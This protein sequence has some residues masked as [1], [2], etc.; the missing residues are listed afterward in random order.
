[1][2][3]RAYAVLLRAIGPATHGVMPMRTLCARCHEM[4]IGQVTS[5]LAT[6]NLLVVTAL[7][8]AGLKERVS[9]AVRS[10]G[11]RN[12]VFVRDRAALDALVANNPFPEATSTRA[13]QV[14]VCFGPDSGFEADWMAGFPGPE[15][16]VLSGHDL[17]V[18]Y[19]DRTISKSK[20]PPGTIERRGRALLTFRNWNT[21]T[22][23][24]RRLGEVN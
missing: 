4:G 24:A 12:D 3:T 2:L 17:Y 8:A 14:I 23:I 1:M 10:F 9:A 15:R 19:P 20:L 22:G 11:L 16:L 6:G 18:D 7:D 5:Y 21:V 13:S